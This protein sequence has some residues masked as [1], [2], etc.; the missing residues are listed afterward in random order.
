MK[1]RPKL[2]LSRVLAYVALIVFFTWVLGPI[3]W[4]LSLSLKSPGDII[5]I[6][7]SFIFSPTVANYLRVFRTGE[8]MHEFANS[9]IIGVS[10]TVLALVI[11][12]PAAYTLQR[13]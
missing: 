11:G 1:A 6:P 10:S 7:T 8:F 4:A 9:L 2:K 5:R 12:V 13:S 3:L